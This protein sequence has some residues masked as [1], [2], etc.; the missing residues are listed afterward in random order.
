MGPRTRPKMEDGGFTIVAKGSKRCAH[1][2]RG[3]GPRYSPSSSAALGAGDASREDAMQ[4][5]ARG[6][7]LLEV[8]HHSQ[9]DARMRQACPLVRLG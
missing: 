6:M 8:R 3:K 2:N 4:A 7:E 1:G 5:V 9:L